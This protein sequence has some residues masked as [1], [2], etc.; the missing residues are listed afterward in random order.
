MLH[1]LHTFTGHRAAVY[2]LARGRKAGQ[3]LSAGGD[4]WI[5]EWNLDKPDAGR[6]IASTETRIFSLYAFPDRNQLVA[7]NMEGG[8]HWINL[9]NP[10]QNRNVQHHHKG[11]FDLLPLGDKL[12]S[13]GGDGLLT[14]WDVRNARAQESVQLSH[15]SLRALAYSEQRRELA[16]GASD[17]NIYFLDS[18]SLEL[19]GVLRN[20][21]ENSVFTVAYSPDQKHLLSGGRDAWLKVWNLP[22]GHFAP[23]VLSSKNPEQAAHLFTINHIVFSPDALFFATAS[24]DKT[25]KIWDARSFKLL[26]VLDTIRHG[27]HINSVNRLLWLENVLISAGDDKSL[28]IWG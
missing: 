15:Q 23:P 10:E 14:R 25:V 21:H 4:G 3:F 9:E 18:Q 6:V 13:A 7:G 28:N 16:V 17:N 27:G 2:A 8:L 22:E 12:L 11:V 20:A 5:V 19:K 1:R 24:R 26:K